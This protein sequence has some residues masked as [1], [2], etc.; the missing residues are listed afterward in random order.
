MLGELILPVG[1]QPDAL[2]S[3]WLK[4]LLAPLDLH[5]N[6]LNRVLR[7]AQNY[8]GRALTPDAGVAFGHIHLSVFVP[9]EP[10]SR[11]QSWG[12]FRIEK[13]DSA[14]QNLAHPDHTVEFY[15]YRERS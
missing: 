9:D 11:A 6:F 3:L 12:F 10:V 2:I 14:E 1:S 15:L 7:S 8:A 13:I 5:E 4:E